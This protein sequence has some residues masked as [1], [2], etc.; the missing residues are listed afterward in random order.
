[1][2][3]NVEAVRRR[4]AF[5]ARGTQTF[6]VGFMPGIMV[7]SAITAL[8]AS[9]PGLT[10]EVVR[11]GWSDQVQV[12]RDG[13]DDVSYVRMPVDHRG[14]R[15]VPLATEPRVAVVASTHRL[16]GKDEVGIGD[17]VDDHLLQNPDAVPE[18]RDIA[19]EIR[20]GV[21]RARQEEVYSIEEKL[22]HVAVGRGTAILPSSVA[23]YYRRPDLSTLRVTDIGP[24]KICLA[25][26]AVRRTK[27]IRAFVKERGRL[28][29]A[30][31]LGS[32]S[33]GRHVADADLVAVS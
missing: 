19:T 4:V 2:L 25:W 24:S 7:T 23:A 26:D 22:E 12:L 14:L 3:A 9:H 32:S 31:R 33:Q 20:A 29:L 13:R 1:M 16:A 17:F 30:D 6:T 21:P 15:F 5:A 8:E 18:W 28:A 10:V 11:T 27:V